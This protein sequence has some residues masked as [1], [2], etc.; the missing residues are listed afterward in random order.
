MR[1]V[2]LH[3]EPGSD[4]R[5][6]LEQLAQ[7]QNASGF[8]LG[9]VGNL[10][11]AAFQCPGKIAP[12]VLRGELEIITLQGTLS[13]EGVHLHLSL[14]DGE[15]RVW[16]GHL[17]PGS[18]VLKGADLLVGLLESTAAAGT[19]ASGA[20]ASAN[21]PLEPLEPRV[22]IAVRSGCPFSRRALR[23][24]RTLGIPH[25]LIEPSADGPVPQVFF[26]GELIGGYDELAQRHGRG[27][28]EAL[29][30]S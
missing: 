6:S 26:D 11:Q 18:R 8:V 25:R 15:C 17:E 10:A 21:E 29:R 22:T 30:Q 7:E 28:L 4:L 5:R 16:G 2:P 9:V 12:T 3:L 13:P 14:S 19:E 27:E 24:L 23:M 1:S 20:E